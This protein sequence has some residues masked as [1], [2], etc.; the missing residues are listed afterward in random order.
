MLSI[1]DRSLRH[2]SQLNQVLLHIQS[3]LGAQ[4]RTT[5]PPTAEIIA[6]RH[7]CSLWFGLSAPAKFHFQYQ[8][9]DQLKHR[10]RQ[11]IIDR[12]TAITVPKDS[13]D[14][15][16]ASEGRTLDHI[17]F[18]LSGFIQGIKISPI[19]TTSMDYFIAFIER[20][21]EA[22]NVRENR[23]HQNPSECFFSI[24][25]FRQKNILDPHFIKKN[26]LLPSVTGEG[27]A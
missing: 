2:D 20:V 1:Q 26:T 7:H 17:V 18:S 5:P 24:F 19:F 4:T 9:H 25:L 3:F 6:S 23:N 21:G 14:S 27:L 15:F 13:R 22:E 10:H 8:A 16:F 12:D 11:L